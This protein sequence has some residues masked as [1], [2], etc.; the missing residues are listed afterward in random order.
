MTTFIG[1]PVAGTSLYCTLAELKSSDV[2][3]T[4]AT[5][6]DDTFLTEIITAVSRAI[7]NETG[8]YFYKSAAH[9][10]RYFSTRNQERCYVGDVVS[11]TALYTDTSVG[12]RTYPY[13]WATTD[14]DLWPYDAATASEPEPYRYID[15]TP[16]G[17]Y[18]FPTNV[19]KGIKLDA[20]FGWPEVPTAIAKACLLWSARIFKRY[21]SV[22]GVSSATPFGQ[23][24]VQA[25]P[26][27]DVAA[28]LAN[29]RAVAV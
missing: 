14:Y 25:K 10:I 7:D 18:Q 21:Q 19:A 28:I 13:T 4:P 12:D 3:N 24:L 22:L 27:P 11:V 16:Q 29:Y 6:T 26:D 9:E 2:L 20:V 23:A 17:L 8:R 15:K 5:A 1:T